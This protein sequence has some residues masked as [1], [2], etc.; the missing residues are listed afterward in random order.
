MEQPSLPAARAPAV[1]VTVGGYRVLGRLA[2][3]G[4]SELFMAEEAVDGEAL[5]Y[6]VIKLLPAGGVEAEA[7][8][9]FLREGRTLL[10]LDHPN[11]CHSYAF[12]KVGARCYI[13]MEWIDGV[14]LRELL[15]AARDA[16]RSLSHALS[17][18]LIAQVAAGLEHAHTARDSQRT[19]LRVVH[20]DVNPTNVMIRHDGVVKLIDFGVAQ[21]A[22]RRGSS[23][24][25]LVRGKLAYMAPEQVRGGEV[26]HRADIFALGV[27]LYELLTGT[28]LYR[29]GSREATADAVLEEPVPSLRAVAPEVPEQL[30]AIVQ[31]ALQKDSAARFASAGE[32]GGALE[33]YLVSVGEPMGARPLATLMRALF[34]HHNGQPQ[35][36]LLSDLAERFSDPGPLPSATSPASELP[37]AEPEAFSTE[38]EPSESRVRARAAAYDAGGHSG[39]VATLTPLT[40]VDAT[41]GDGE[42]AVPARTVSEPPLASTTS[43]EQAQR[44]RRGGRVLALTGA[45]AALIALCVYAA[46]DEATHPS[47]AHPTAELEPTAKASAAV[48]AAPSEPAL[49]AQAEAASPEAAALP[50]AVP[51]PSPAAEPPASASSNGLSSEP[52]AERK[53]RARRRRA[54]PGFIADPGF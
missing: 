34:P 27:C 44:P 40:P 49:P 47:P 28:R 14:S 33:D 36:D 52:S 15:I 31:R 18:N 2:V 3:G 38:S 30:D 39:V 13:A 8:R 35:L 25:Q 48:P 23:D 54:S 6:V 45:A 50:A 19:P 7:E 32:L 11:V 42:R 46:R 10:R 41:G 20:R 5:R 26:D 53:T 12:G 1:A 29:R 4:M 51:A 24:P 43:A 17:A 22:E 37:P 9:L 16:G 21:V